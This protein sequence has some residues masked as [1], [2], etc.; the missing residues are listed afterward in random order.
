MVKGQELITSPVKAVLPGV[1][2]GEIIELAKK[3]GIKVIE[4]EFSFKD[5]DKLDGMFISG[6]S[7][8]VLPINEVDN[9]KLNPQNEVIKQ[10]SEIY[11]NE[12]EIYLAK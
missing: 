3:A 10:L 12:I 6:T 4:E 9:I 5:I 8:K 7:P 11:N 2:R 1:T